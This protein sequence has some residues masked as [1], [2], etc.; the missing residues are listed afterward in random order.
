MSGS[1]PTHRGVVSGQVAEIIVSLDGK[2][3]RRGSGYRVG[4]PVVAAR[5][6]RISDRA[7]ELTAQ[8]VGFPL[9]K[10]KNDDGS[11]VL[12]DGRPRYRDWCQLDGSVAV[13]S[14]RR[15]GTLEVAV[16]PPERD[17]DPVV[18]PWEG[19]SGAAVW[20]GDRI[21]GVIAKHHRSDGLGRLAA[22]RLDRALDGR[23]PGNEAELRALLNLPEVLP[24]VV[25]PS[26]GERVITAY[27]EQVRVIA[28]DNLLD[29]EDELDE[30]VEFCAGNRPYAWWRAGPWAGKSALMA[31]FVLHPPPDVDVV[32]FFVT[33]QLADQSDSDACLDALI[34][35]SGPG[36]RVYLFAHETLQQV[37]EQSFGKSLGAYPDRLQR[38]CRCA[39][40]A[41]EAQWSARLPRGLEKVEMTRLRPT[42]GL[43]S[44]VC[45][46][47]PPSR[48]GGW[49]R[50]PASAGPLLCHQ[51]GGLVMVP[52]ASLSC[53][54][55][56]LTARTPWR[57]CLVK[58]GWVRCSARLITGCG[59]TIPTRKPS[60]CLT[61]RMG[62]I[63]SESLLTTTKMSAS[64][65]NASA[66][67]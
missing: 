27:Q 26:H 42:P 59:F 23:D 63:K 62:S 11:V 54:G 53:S 66:S 46:V 57:I 17:P 16:R 31:W 28:P 1:A 65:R 40:G 22:A 13:L 14:N 8:T 38:S 20:I 39:S 41:L 12:D 45:L 64:A 30:L 44:P 18:S 10:L 36:E 58:L 3:G 43:V 9:F 4:P 29:R 49:V 34:D 55:N 2:A 21:V 60:S 48:L 5:F 52:W 7:E 56:W 15:E 51:V 47:H 32:S 67:K 19:M 35:T 50:G 24:D 33:A 25:P 61:R 37:A 6:G